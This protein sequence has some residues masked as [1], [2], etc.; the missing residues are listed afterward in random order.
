METVENCESVADA[1]TRTPNTTGVRSQ[2]RGRDGKRPNAKQSR[3]EEAESRKEPEENCP[4][5][6]VVF[7]G[8]ARRKI[9][10]KPKI[11]L[12]V[13]VGISTGCPKRKVTNSVHHQDG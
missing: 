1:T 7:V 9:R 4:G 5:G 12:A 13:Q 8:A 3:K 6:L 11:L 10:R 2:E